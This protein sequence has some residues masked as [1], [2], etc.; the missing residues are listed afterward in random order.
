ME[1]FDLLWCGEY[2]HAWESKERDSSAFRLIAVSHGKLCAVVG[3]QE[4]MLKTSDMLLISPGDQ[5]VMYDA[6]EGRE[7]LH[8]YNASFETHDSK[9]LKRLHEMDQVTSVE[10]FHLVKSCFHRIMQE[11]EE[12]QDFY[13]LTSS[14]Y[15][16]MILLE[17]M[18]GEGVRKE[19]RKKEIYGR[20]NS[21]NAEAGYEPGKIYR[22]EEM[23]DDKLGGVNLVGSP[24]V[25]SKP[26]YEFAGFSEEEEEPNIWGK[27]SGRTADMRIVEKYCRENYRKQVSLEELVELV[28]YNKTSLLQKFREAY[29]TTPR[30]YIIQIRLHKAKELLRNTDYSV[31][32]ISDMVGFA[33]VHYFSRFFKEKEKNSP[34]EYRMKYKKNRF[35]VLDAC[36][37]T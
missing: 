3:G 19:I 7:A 21:G 35:Y 34:L 12:K 26:E 22:M 24:S 33:S 2:T 23:A 37:A 31:S 28:H 13:A 15:F 1:N 20:E 29:G 10:N 32:E 36:G 30:N 6:A 4:K 5:C 18:P 27:D 14:C 8:I 11:C 9:L 25:E 16:W 17:L